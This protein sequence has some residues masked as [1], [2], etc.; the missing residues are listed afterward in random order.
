MTQDGNLPIPC[1][2]LRK[3]LGG[4]GMCVVYKR[5]TY[6]KLERFVALKFLTDFVAHDLAG[7]ESFPAEAKAASA[8]NHS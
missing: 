7:S 5:K 8:L 6:S 3:K 4:A 1:N 2:Q